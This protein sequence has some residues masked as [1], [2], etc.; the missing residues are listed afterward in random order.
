MSE[1]TFYWLG[2]VVF[3]LIGVALLIDGLHGMFPQFALAHLSKLVVGIFW[4]FKD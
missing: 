3:R 2:T 1:E 4:T